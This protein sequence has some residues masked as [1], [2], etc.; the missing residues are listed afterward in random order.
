MPADSFSFPTHVCRSLPPS[1]QTPRPS[2]LQILTLGARHC[3]RCQGHKHRRST[4]FSEG[5]E[6]QTHCYSIMGQSQRERFVKVLWGKRKRKT[7]RERCLGRFRV[8]WAPPLSAARMNLLLVQR[9]RGRGEGKT[10]S[11]KPPGLDLHRVKDTW[12]AT[13]SSVRLQAVCGGPEGT[14]QAGPALWRPLHHGKFT[15][16]PTVNART[17]IHTNTFLG[18]L[19][20]SHELLFV[21]ISFQ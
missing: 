2:H 17:H 11:S 21:N 15:L 13:S 12:V 5:R 4:Q 18:N 20:G 14:G 3:T 8:A 7:G 6:E 9:G 19:R 10:G 1:A 16:Y